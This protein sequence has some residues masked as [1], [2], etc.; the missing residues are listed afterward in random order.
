MDVED[1]FRKLSNGAKF[2]LKK[3]QY[4]AQKLQVIKPK[5]VVGPFPIQINSQ[6]DVQ[7]KKLDYEELTQPQESLSTEL[8]LIGSITTDGN[9]KKHLSNKD[10]R[11]KEAALNQEKINRFRNQQKISVKGHDVPPPI[12]NF[13]QLVTEYGVG[14][15]IVDNIKNLGYSVPTPIQMQA[16]PVMLKNQQIL[17]CAPTGSGKTAAFL[18]PL[19]HH[20]K[21]PRRKGFR[22]VVVSPTRELAKQTYRECLK[23]SEGR[24]LRIH[25]IS[26]ASLAV[27]KFGPESS[28]RFDILITTPNRL[29]YLLQQD[30]PVISLA[31]VKWLVID[32]SDKLFEAS[33]DG[34]RDQLA[35]IYRA[36]DSENVRR[37]LFSATHTPDVAR[38]A[39]KNLKGLVSV[40]IGHRNTAADIVEQQLLF[41][42]TEAGKLVAFRDIVRKGLTPPV[43]VFVQTKERAKELF[44]ELLYD[45]IN[46]DVI[47][48]DRTQLQRD[49]VV[50]SFRRG[51]IWVLI[52]TELMGRGIDFKGVNLVI[53]YDFPPS[54]ISYIHR[55]GRTGRAGNPGKAITFFTESDTVNLRSIAQMV[56]DSGC[57]VPEYLL[58]LKKSSKRDRRKLEK[59]APQRERIS[60]V[61]LCD[62]EKQKKLQQKIRAIKRKK[63][64]GNEDRPQASKQ[65]KQKL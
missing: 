22:A 36:C 57:E 49:N 46:V 52:C 62:I 12:E 18:V 47:H 25:I 38:W 37:A 8:K 63:K 59:K 20:L 60:T 7:H 11:N 48:A 19:I 16:I 15:D 55:I 40:T 2:D 10:I 31:N 30:P 34:F 51:D 32:E 41:V 39:H 6:N 56:Q 3:F 29:V 13:E 1:L 24:N 9:K 45:G 61:P 50:Q 58:K 65:K 54:V 35:V 64:E 44:N 21:G 5:H 17:A 53:N 43:L 42:G 33:E 4:D 23:L 26:K 14:Q 28:K 27:K